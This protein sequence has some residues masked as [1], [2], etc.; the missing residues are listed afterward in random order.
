MLA[1][2]RLELQRWLSDQQTLYSK[3]GLTLDLSND[4]FPADFPTAA[5]TNTNSAAFAL[6]SVL[7]E[8]LQNNLPAPPTDWTKNSSYQETASTNN[9]NLALTLLTNWQSTAADE[10]T[11]PV[12]QYIYP[13]ILALALAQTADLDYE[14][15]E[16]A[17]QLRDNLHNHIDY[18]QRQLLADQS[19]NAIKMAL[20]GQIVSHLR[21]LMAIVDTAAEQ[22]LA[23]LPHVVRIQLMTEQPLLCIAWNQHHDSSQADSIRDRNAEIVHPLFVP[24]DVTLELL[25]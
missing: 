17:M 3:A 7:L 8:P 24:P 15:V 4:G 20:S 25:K 16:Q 18:I 1:Y 21:D 12:V 22:Q 10:R 13:Q 14:S 23:T 2:T 5:F 6:S 9:I 11:T 19:G